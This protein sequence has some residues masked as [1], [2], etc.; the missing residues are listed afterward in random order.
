VITKPDIHLRGMDRNGVMLDGT[1]PGAPECSAVD[2]AQDFGPNDANGKPAGR[3]GV[4][5]YRTSGVSV[6]NLSACNFLT[7]DMGGGD[8]LWFDGGASTGTQNMNAWRGAYLTASSTYFKDS[9]SPFM[10]YGIYA[11][12]VKGPGVYTQVYANNSADAAY[13]IGACPN[14]NTILDHAH[15]ENSDLGYSGTNSGGNL[16]I[17]YSEFDNNQSG[18]VTNSQNNDDAP[19]P[20]DGVCPSST[21]NPQQ[22]A[23]TQRTEA[24]WVFQ[25]NSVHDNNNP[26]VPAT[27][28]AA[29]GPVGSGVVISGGRHDIVT[30]NSIF[31]NKAWGVLLV[32]FPDV[33]NPPDVAN[34]N[35]GQG[36]QKFNGMTACYFDDFANEVSGN[37]FA[38]NG[39]YGNTTNGDMAEISNPNPDGN[40]WHDNVEAGGG[41][42]TSEPPQ[43]Q[44]THGSCH[45]PNSGDPVA[46]PLGTQVSCDSQL[47][48]SCPATPAGNYPRA[49]TNQDIQNGMKL[50]PAQA[51]MPDPCLDVPQN[52]W[53]PNNPANPAAYPVPGPPYPP[54]TRAAGSNPCPSRQV[55]VLRLRHLFRGL[56][57]AKVTVNGH[58]VRISRKLVVR[59]TLTNPG[60]T[61]VVRIRGRLRNGGRVRQ[62]RR[63]SPCTAAT[64]KKHKRRARKR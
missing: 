9:S 22:P 60:R 26:N 31:N 53:C 2:S 37:T 36:G 33:G 4:I 32:P 14:C 12:N 40:C 20:Q 47:L 59:I 54:P 43:I 34:C 64:V 25:N 44:Q 7:G 23:G 15:A 30:H 51:S 5:V 39:G 3:D 29:A 13:Y 55:V 27:G 16:I 28:T 21:K 42:P 48:F 35:G 19:S 61:Q 8:V 58:R 10:N 38:N 57:S 62:R 49:G 18:F 41:T 11:S 45:Q 50:P 63:Y 46:S 17:Q 52:P 56:R 24:C 6:E 1:K